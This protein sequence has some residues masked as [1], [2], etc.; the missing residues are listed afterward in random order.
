MNSL[1][2]I[3]CLEVSGEGKV[4]LQSVKIEA[5]IEDLKC[6]VNIT[7]K[8]CNL[9]K[10]NIEAV[11]T[12]PLPFNA[13]LLDLTIKTETRKLKGIV[14]EKSTAEDMYEDAITDGDAAFML[15]Q[16]EP[17]LFTMN[18][19]NLQPEETIEISMTYAE[20]FKWAEN[21]LRFFIPTTIAPRYG[22]PIN[23]GLHP[24][25]V[26]EINYLNDN[27][28]N[29]TISI[30]GLLT[31]ALIESP[32]HKIIKD[33]Q[34]DQIIISLE[35]G[36]TLMDRDF[37]L[38]LVMQKE[39]KYAA[40][41]E[42]DNNG[43]VALASFYP[44]FPAPKENLPRY[45]NIVIDCSGSMGGDS[46]SQA[47]SAICE[48]LK[49]LR[50]QDR[51]NIIRFG[52]SYQ[53]L[54][55]SPVLAD[56][57]NLK[58][59]M[60]IAEIIDAD[61][62]GTEIEQAIHAAVLERIPEKM[63]GEVLLITDGEVWEW[64]KVKIM[65]AVS[66]YRFFTVGVGSS[67]SEPFIQSL[68]D[69][70][71]GA[72][73]IVSPNENMTERI[74]R[75]FKRIYYPK[76]VD[77]QV[78]WPGK[79]VNSS[80]DYI[81]SIYDGDTLNVFGRFPEKPKGEVEL[82]AVLED[83]EIFSQKIVL[84]DGGKT[85]SNPGL[86]C[87]LSRLAAAQEIK[88]MDDPEKIAETGVKYQLMSG[89]TNYLAI[90]VKTDDKKAINLPELRKTP[91]MLAAGWG[92][93]G[94]C[95]EISEGAASYSLRNC[96]REPINSIGFLNDNTDSLYERRLQNWDDMNN[97]DLDYFIGH[98][99]WLNDGQLYRELPHFTTLNDLK[100]HGVPKAIIN[101]LQELVYNGYEENKVVVIF[102][103]LLSGNIKYKKNLGRQVKRKIAKQ[104]KKLPVFPSEIEQKITA[105]IGTYLQN[106]N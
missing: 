62:G 106:F 30:Q 9:E 105:K 98:L 20:L 24:H 66:G 57:N 73:E 100:V 38:N 97:F 94:T 90:D 27:S 72:C 7:Q 54:F 29:I 15:E 35:K 96:L 61:M 104:Y 2:R 43:Y 46:I 67:V 102:L 14:I 49:L 22:D 23:S 3:P 85:Q 88:F 6:E 77:V 59:A 83:G 68:A 64:E 74:V 21:S 37:I 36:K 34:Q 19:G 17:G 75:H 69:V 50:P 53:T 39:E 52:S 95:M 58:K 31:G 45:M 16:I 18:V 8:Y 11:Y 1:M 10:V 82:R 13:V 55:R 33:K 65:A 4:A 71:G 56:K 41:F 70:T 44:Q 47:R 51:F 42:P 48:I 28:M 60:T 25:Q 5:E 12:F 26:P 91:Q 92:G 93:T 99:N 103:Y 87:T 76:A 79:D 81:Q 89:H 80:P 40:R 86:P 78:R 32:S 101:A 63:S 84:R